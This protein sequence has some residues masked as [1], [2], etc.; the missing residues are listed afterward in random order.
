MCLRCVPLFC[1]LFSSF[2]VFHLLHVYIWSCRL[3]CHCLC[4]LLKQLRQRR[5]NLRA[6][7][8]LDICSNCVVRTLSLSRRIQLWLGVLWYKID[9]WCKGN[10]HIHF[11]VLPFL[12]LSLSL[13]LSPCVPFAFS[14][15]SLHL[16]CLQW[17][18]VTLFHFNWHPWI[19]LTCFAADNIN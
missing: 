7:S 15:P 1:L 17:T 6:Q 8:N 10:S 2:C 9:T 3:Y 18:H 13:S 11:C 4:L 5:N 19:K 16:P 14:L 12:S